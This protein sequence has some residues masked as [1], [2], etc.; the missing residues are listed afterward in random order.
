VTLLDFDID[1]NG[2]GQQVLQNKF[3]DKLLPLRLYTLLVRQRL[4]V[5]TTTE[6]ECSS[7]H[8]LVGN[9]VFV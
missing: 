5:T 8:Y 6:Y 4:Q 2:G 1:R 7:F 3:R 9:G